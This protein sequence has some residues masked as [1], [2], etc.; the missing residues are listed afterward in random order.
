MFVKFP[1]VVTRA[2]ATGIAGAEVRQAR[3][4]SE[5]FVAVMHISS[6]MPVGEKETLIT[7]S[8]QQKV[9]V[10]L[11]GDD[12][13]DSIKGVLREIKR[14]ELYGDDPDEEGETC[15]T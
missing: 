9:L 12:V 14:R 3:F 6:I 4:H 5:I 8:G 11:S 7:L 10:M 15:E 13:I 1:V 2:E